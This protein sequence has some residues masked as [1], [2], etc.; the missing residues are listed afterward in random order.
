MIKWK[1]DVLAELK[2]AGYTTYRIRKE[3]LMG[4]MMLTKIRNNELPS[5]ATLDVICNLLNCQPG[6]LLEHIN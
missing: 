1:V 4:Q 2:A 3:N 6:D 5:W